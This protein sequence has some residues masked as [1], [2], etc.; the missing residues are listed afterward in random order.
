MKT[1]F[2]FQQ[3]AV[4]DQ[5]SAMKIGTDGVLLGSW[6]PIRDANTIVDVGTGCGLIALMIGQRTVAQRATVRAIDVDRD[7]AQQALENFSASPWRDRLPSHVEQIHISLQDFADDADAESR[8]DLAVCN[9]P[10][11]TNDFLP[12][13]DARRVA[14]HTSLL[15]R[16]S[17]FLNSRRVLSPTG[18]LCLVLPYAQAAETIEVA[19]ETE[20]R[21]WARTDVRPNPTGQLKRVLLEFGRQSFDGSICADRDP[22]HDEL[23]VEVTRNEFTDDYRALTEQFHLR[24]AKDKG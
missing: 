8:F 22:I 16:R 18:R 19:L 14:R 24:F 13:R 7:A 17:L 12:S 6:A 10:Y 20:F 4:R 9:P 11:F 2:R 1:P 23:V 3:F 21:L 5:G 15:P